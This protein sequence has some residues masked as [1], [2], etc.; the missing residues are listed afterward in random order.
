M[1]LPTVL[2]LPG[3]LEDADA[4]EP[5]IAGTQDVAI[6]IV[7][8]MTRDDSIAA[9]AAHAL[10]QAPEGPIAVAGHSMGGYVALEIM[11][12]APERVARLALLNTN[13]RPDAPESRENRQ[14]LMALAD[15]DFEG[16]IN[17]LMPRL[18]TD[19]H[20]KDP[21]LT[22]AVAAMAH[23]V[24]RE[25]FKRQERAII[26]RADSRP[27]LAAIRCPT[28]VVAARDDA[29]VPVAWLEELANGIPGA[30][31]AVI[32]DCGHMSTIERPAE[33]VRILRPWI[34]GG[35]A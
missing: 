34:Q 30:N 20:L 7:A 5:L 27:H 10:R 31:L 29:I 6:C 2:L 23:G 8:D 21:V 15:R 35:E 1:T 13:A 12:Q 32:E 17:A 14:R 25:A 11:R 22:G 4:F 33:V 19:A 16:V 26:D 24:G 3:L 28:Q 9:L 18:M